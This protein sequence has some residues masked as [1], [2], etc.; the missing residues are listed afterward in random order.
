MGT[1]EGSP[2]RES[3]R[4]PLHG[5]GKEREMKPLWI[6]AFG[7]VGATAT[8]LAAMRLRKSIDWVY[9]Q[10]IRSRDSAKSFRTALQEEAWRRYNKRM[11]EAYEEEMERVERIKR[12]QSVFDRERNKHMRGCGGR[13]EKETNGHNQQFQRD[14][15]YWKAEASFRNQ[16]ANSQRAHPPL[17]HHYS[18][19]GLD[20]SRK[21]P[22]TDTEIKAAFRAKAME[23]HP[24]QNQSN[25]EVAEVKFKEVLRSY[26]S[27][28]KERKHSI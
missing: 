18:V 8:T 15:C 11:Q 17:S 24:D 12:M 9:S 13:K 26:E 23:F 3:W 14:D 25:K 2:G 16:W 20:R 28:K 4:S 7:L 1:E 21:T 5:G 22:Y 10:L 27:I 19:L 6:I